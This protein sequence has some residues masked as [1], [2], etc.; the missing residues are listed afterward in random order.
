MIFI[1][2]IPGKSAKIWQDIANELNAHGFTTAAS[3]RLRVALNRND[4]GNKL[5]LKLKSTEK[6]GGSRSDVTVEGNYLSLKLF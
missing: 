4:I 6:H 3:I 5:G 2:D 1:K